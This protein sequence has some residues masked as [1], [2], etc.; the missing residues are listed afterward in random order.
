MEDGYVIVAVG[1]GRM[2]IT[3]DVG[4]GVVAS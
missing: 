4:G 1:V 3:C 2:T